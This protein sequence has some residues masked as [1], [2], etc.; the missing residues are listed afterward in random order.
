[1]RIAILCEC[2]GRL[3]DLFIAAGH[4]AISCD[5]KASEVPG[6]HHQ[7]DMFEFIN[8][9]PPGYFDLIIVHPPCTY[10]A[11]TGNKWLK[12]QPPRESGALVGHERRVA[13][14]QAIQFF[15][16]CVGLRK[17]T[18]R[19]VIENPVGIMSTE[20][21]K[22]DQIVTPLQFGHKEPKETCFWLFGVQLL[23]ST[24]RR[25][26]G[27]YMVMKSGKRLP[28]WFVNARKG[29][30]N[31]LSSTIR[32]RTFEGMAVAMV[33]QWTNKELLTLF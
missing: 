24:H 33:D 29:D 1:M 20:F 14:K 7:G 6:P 21:R 8:S 26:R 22:P 28:L 16:S 12:D 5:L 17:K 30:D 13:Q 11:V 3:R 19:L 18:K 10:L 2:S 15:M 4:E 31:D 32:S 9:F 25:S 27:E 23:E